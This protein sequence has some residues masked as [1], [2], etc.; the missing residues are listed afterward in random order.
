MIS[1]ASSTMVFMRGLQCN[2]PVNAAAVARNLS[3]LVP[4]P[5]FQPNEEHG[6]PYSTCHHIPRTAYRI[7]SRFEKAE[8]WSKIALTIRN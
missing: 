3:N 4:A 6:L 5:A 2:A 8:I 1:P 7:S